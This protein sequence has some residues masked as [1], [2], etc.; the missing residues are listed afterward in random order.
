MLEAVEALG[1]LLEVVLEI[2]AGLW[3]VVRRDR[4]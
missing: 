4:R 1:C 2:V 3:D